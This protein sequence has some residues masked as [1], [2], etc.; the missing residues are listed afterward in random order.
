MGEKTGMKEAGMIIDDW[1]F[2][3][4]SWQFFKALVIAA[5][6]STVAA[7]EMVKQGGNAVNCQLTATDGTTGCELFDF[8]KHGRPLVV[9]FGSCT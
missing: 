9:N 5:Y 4:G 8:M 6:E 1:A 2:T 3:A 7:N